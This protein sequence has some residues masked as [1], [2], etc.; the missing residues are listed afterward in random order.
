MVET[1]DFRREDLK[2]QILGKIGYPIGRP[3]A[4]IKQK[5]VTEKRQIDLVRGYPVDLT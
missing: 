2:K 4:F 3:N 1:L 5:L